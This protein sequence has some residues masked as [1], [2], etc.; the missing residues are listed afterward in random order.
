MKAEVS[1]LIYIRLCVHTQPRSEANHGYERIQAF[2][3][4]LSAICAQICILNALRTRTDSFRKR[5]EKR[6]TKTTISG[7]VP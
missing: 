4:R 5:E 2:I 6:R 3:F 1:S 7:P